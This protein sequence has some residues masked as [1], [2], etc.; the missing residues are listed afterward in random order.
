M[1]KQ[2]PLTQ[3]KVALVD[4]DM[5]EFLNQWRW[6]AAFDG[7]N[8]YAERNEKIVDKKTIV[9]M[10]RIVINALASDPMVDH[11]NG[12]GLDNR[13][14]NL[15]FCVNSENGGNRRKSKNN[16]SGYKGVCWNKRQ[17]KYVGYIM[18][19]HQNFFLGYFDTPEEAAQA[20][21][22]RARELFGEFAR[23]NFGA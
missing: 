15:R 14:Q 10:H 18:K 13:R 4:D 20:Y 11:Q 23:T 16:T 17:K 8:W 21:D 6:F 5:Y 1:T 7:C 3:G 9:L 22:A 19:Q 2:I 12:N